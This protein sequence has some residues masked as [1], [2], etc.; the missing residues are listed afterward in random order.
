MKTRQYTYNFEPEMY[1][2][3]LSTNI[4][5]KKKNEDKIFKSLVMG[6][7]AKEISKRYHYAE[8]TIW[9]RRRDIY[10]KT[11]KYMI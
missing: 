5:N 3:I 7:N 1:K 4:L 8:S 11:K 10:N 9:N 2:Y 6:Y